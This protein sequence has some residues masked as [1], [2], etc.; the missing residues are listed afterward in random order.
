MGANP[1]M[2]G[3]AFMKRGA[4]FD[5]G[6]LDRCAQDEKK[7]K[8]PYRPRMGVHIESFNPFD[9]NEFLSVEPLSEAKLHPEMEKHTDSPNFRAHVG[10]PDDKKPPFKKKGK[11]AGPMESATAGTDAPGKGDTAMGK[12]LKKNSP[13]YKDDEEFN[14]ASGGSHHP[15]KKMEWREAMAQERAA[16]QSGARPFDLGE[17]IDRA[18]SVLRDALIEA[19]TAQRADFAKS[20]ALGLVKRLKGKV[21]HHQI[22]WMSAIAEAFVNKNEAK[23]RADFA[24][25]DFDMKQFMADFQTYARNAA[26]SPAGKKLL[27]KFQKGKRNG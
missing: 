7:G 22:L 26:K 3:S 8:L 5:A 20:L 19:T 15:V 17:G 18:A 27:A 2:L 11:K 16:R 1:M 21:P 9:A 10:D 6:Y 14:P 24:S 4:M 25:G 13:A 23:L 12:K